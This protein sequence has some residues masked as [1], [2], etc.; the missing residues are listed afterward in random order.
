M[1][2][3]TIP[4]RKKANVV[5]EARA[6]RTV[7]GGGNQ[8]KHPNEHRRAVSMRSATRSAFTR[9]R[10]RRERPGALPPAPMQRRQSLRTAAGAFFAGR[11]RRGAGPRA[12][13][14]PV[15]AAHDGAECARCAA[16]SHAEIGSRGGH[17]AGSSWYPRAL[18]TAASTR[19][20]SEHPS[21]SMCHPCDTES[22]PFRGN[23]CKRL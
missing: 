23:R 17:G 3:A 5:S 18:A 7:P 22:P 13:F 21:P 11:Y 6:C 1:C 14:V 15:E 9:D 2:A 4:C 20:G 19:T 10:Q 16:P 8:H 12:V